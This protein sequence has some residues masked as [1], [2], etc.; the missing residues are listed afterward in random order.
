MKNILIIIIA[1][2]CT[3]NAYADCS[4]SGLWVFPSGQTIKQNPIFVLDGYDRSQEVV[5]G[6]NKRHYL[7]LKSG[8]KKIKLLVLEICVGDFYLTQA[9]LKPETELEVGLEYTMSIESIGGSPEYESISKDIH[10][11]KW[12]WDFQ[13]RL[14]K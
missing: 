11:G 4:D 7:Y 8:T 5:L 2:F 6:I 12:F 13:V 9:I 14:N 3:A 10:F 1:L